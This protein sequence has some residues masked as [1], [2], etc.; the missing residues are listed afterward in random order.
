V[1]GVDVAVRPPPTPLEP[2]GELARGGVTRRAQ[3]EVGRGGRDDGGHEHEE[4]AAQAEEV[5]KAEREREDEDAQQGVQEEAHALILPA[6]RERAAQREPRTTVPT[7][8]SLPAPRLTYPEG[9]RFLLY[10]AVIGVA[11]Y[12]FIALV[13]A[14][15]R[16]SG[17]QSGGRRTRPG[18]GPRP[19][20]PVAPDDDPA[21]LAELDRRRREAE[22]KARQA[23]EEGGDT[24][25]AEGDDRPASPG[26]AA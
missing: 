25:T 22:R 21:F 14:R 10:L 15:G 8:L 5:A 18:P 6:W 13:Q 23:R 16:R 19:R 11:V 12:L 1:L 3:E 4:P 24:G 2:P 17:G 9:V 7:A 20:G 26:S